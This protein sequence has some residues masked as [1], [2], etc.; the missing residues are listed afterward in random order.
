MN[1]LTNYYKNLC[2]Q[3]QAREKQL[4]QILAEEMSASAAPGIPGVSPGVFGPPSPS[5]SP[6]PSGP[7]TP[8]ATAP[9][10]PDRPD[11][12]GYPGGS[13]D[14]AYQKEW[15]DYFKWWQKQDPAW[16]A[17]NPLPPQP[18]GRGTGPTRRP[19]GGYYPGEPG[20]PIR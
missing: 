20:R 13:Q 11:P 17:K 7:A 6:T 1:Y 14:P 9:Q 2:E 15:Y 4:L 10:G 3:L 5:P 8:P 16:K 19:G 12:R 18:K